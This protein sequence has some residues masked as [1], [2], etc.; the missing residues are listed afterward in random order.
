MRRSI[1]KD[2]ILLT[3]MQ[4]LL[5]GLGLGVNV[6]VNARLGAESVGILTL[7][8]SFF[9]L[10]CM[11]AGGNVFLCVSRFVSEELGKPFR[12]PAGILR[13]CLLV[14][15][16]LSCLTMLLICLFAEPLSRR[17]LHDAAL[18]APIRHM[19]YVLPLITL[20]A[21]LKGWCNALCKAG[22]C[23]AADG[24]EFALHSGLTVL[25]ATLFQP[26][27]A[28]ALCDLTAWSS[29]IAASGEILFLLCFLPRLRAG[30]TG[31]ASLGVWNYLR[32]ALPVMAGSALTSGLS[33]AND[34][35]VP[36]TLR[37]AG[38]SAAEALSQFGIFEAM[39]LPTLFFPSTILCSLAGILVTETARAHMAGQTERIRS[40][41]LRTVCRTIGFSVFVT[42]ILL[43]FGDEIGERLGGGVIAGRMIRLLAPVVPFIYLEIV[44]ESIIKGLGAQVFSS[45]NYL[46]EY[47]VR[48]SIVLICIPLLGFYGIVLSYYASNVLGNTARMIVVLRKTGM[49][50]DPVRF[51]MLPLFAAVL[52]TQVSRAVFLLL[53]ADPGSGLLSMI[54]YIGICGGICAGC[55]H[56]LE[57]KKIPPQMPAGED[58]VNGTDRC[59]C[60]STSGFSSSCSGDSPCDLISCRTSC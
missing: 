54:L 46:C 25:A 29:G 1:L 56:L 53:H 30:R 33:A 27:K 47:A 60:R 57:G 51:V 13:H 55:L 40:L 45:L 24:V 48:I 44:L 14:S 11:I 23:A 20:A 2:T 59:P 16:T 35:L 39:I 5:D 52:G 34:A 32:L 41:A 31:S 36:F 19:A 28:S 37:Q 38:N 8:A 58:A 4:M 3:L 12:H 10:A 17:F 6:L 49:R 7:S 22:L 18:T 26:Q 15:L 42:A 43:T 21:G 50:F 9:R